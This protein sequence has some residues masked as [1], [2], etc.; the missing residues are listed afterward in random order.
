MGHTQTLSN[1]ATHRLALRLRRAAER[2]GYEVDDVAR[3]M[4]VTTAQVKGWFRGDS[5]IRRHDLQDRARTAI[6]VW[7]AEAAT[8]FGAHQ[9]LEP[10]SVKAKLVDVKPKPAVRG[11]GATAPV[12][13]ADYREGYREGYRDG[14]RDGSAK[15]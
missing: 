12:E 9:N 3:E 7:M 8:Q 4:G 11:N 2:R 15:G 6:Q 10:V 1:Q 5:G 13:P 14:F